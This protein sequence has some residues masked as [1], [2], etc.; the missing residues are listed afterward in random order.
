MATEYKLSY[1]ASEIDSKL[2]QIDTLAKKSEIPT[3]VSELTNDSGF[4]SGYTETDPTVSA[5]AKAATKP[6]YTAEEVGAL[7]NTTVIPMPTAQTVTLTIADW[8]DNDDGRYAQNVSVPGVT[9]TTPIVLVD[10]ALTGAD[11]EADAAALA[12]WCPEDGSG[13]SS[14][15]V[16]QGNGTLTFFCTSI[17]SVAIPIN[18]GV[19]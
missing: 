2:E 16:V 5:W 13:P 8:V 14:Q 11:L 3:K 9:S 10:V 7:S 15:N 19:C 17:P 6:T 1:T 18:V 12:A 4:I